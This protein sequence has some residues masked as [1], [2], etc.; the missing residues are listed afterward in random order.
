[1]NTNEQVVQQAGHE[2]EHTAEPVQRPPKVSRG[3]VLLLAVIVL[4]IAAVLGVVGILHRVHANTELE[5]Y[6]S[7]TAAPPVALELPVM[8]QT[9]QEIVIPGN[10]QAFT[11][12]PIYARTT[13]YVKAWYHDIGSH[14]RKGDLLAVIETPELDQQLSQA[15]AD[16][17][18]AEANASLAKVT[19]ERYQDLVGKNAVSQQDTDNALAQLRARN[20][21]VTSA[22][23]NVHR[24]EELQSF[25]RITAP[26][27]GVVTARNID[28]GQLITSTGSTGVS[29]GGAAPANREIFDISSIG[30][31]RVFVNVPQVHA[32]DAKNGTIATL[33]LPQYP[34][35]TFQGKLVRSS[36]AVDPNTRTLLA[37]VDVD[38]RTGELLTGSYTEVHLH[39]AKPQPAL[40]VPISAV[41]LQADGLHV[42]VVDKNDIA[43]VI[44]VTPGRDLG[45]SMEIVSGLQPGE[46]VI[47]NPPDS[48]I[49]GEK[50]RVVSRPGQKS[51]AGQAQ[52]EK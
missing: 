45:S 12:A 17:A 1:M 7:A 19:S 27:D 36:D 46:P 41:V 38:N 35:K 16:L 48:L 32:P 28:I 13:G 40:V 43:H 14:V 44:R 11:S 10:M 34:G 29:T 52:G 49:D 18:T 39:T 33:T 4:L 50:V 26:F 23:A 22:E 42:A 31:L 21:E 37:E 25:E 9:A 30:T 5:H 3:S 20:T 6:T 8:Q 51:S 2:P 47:T 15:K 24:L